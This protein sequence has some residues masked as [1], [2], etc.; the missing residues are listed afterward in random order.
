MDEKTNTNENVVLS[1]EC[2]YM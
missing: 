1:A 2:L